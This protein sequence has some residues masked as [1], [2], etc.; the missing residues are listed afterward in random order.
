MIMLYIIV[1]PTFDSVII[2]LLLPL[3]LCAV[4]SVNASVGSRKIPDDQREIW[5]RIDPA[6]RD[7]TVHSQFDLSLRSFASIPTLV[8]PNFWLLLLFLPF[9]ASVRN[10]SISLDRKVV[11]ASANVENA[12]KKRSY[13]T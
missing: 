4:A 6:V 9:V 11:V 1:Q 13:C 10:R 12:T 8:V 2:F 3:S 5:R 7:V